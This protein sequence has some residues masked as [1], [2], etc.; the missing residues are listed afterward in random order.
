MTIGNTVALG[1]LVLSTDRLLALLAIAVFIGLVSF[2]TR[3][4]PRPTS[5][6]ATAAVVAGLV[7]GRIGY[8]AMHI[9]SYSDDPLSALAI[10]QGG[11]SVTAGIVGAALVLVATL[12]RSAALHRSLASLG[13]AVMVWAAAAHLL[14]EDAAIPLPKG[15][16]AYTIDG[17]PVAIDSFRGKPFVINLWATWCGPCQREMPML[18]RAA[19]ARPAVPVLFIDQGETPDTVKA[20]LATTRLTSPLLLVDRSQDFSRAVGSGALPTTVFVA[21][22]GMIRESHAGEI[23]RAALDD[24]IDDILETNQ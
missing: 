13:I 24:G 19:A 6:A 18:V 14:V 22:D 16:V 10:W 21:A 3:K 17:R 5:N 12:R 7:M 15:L 23:S 9:P 20:F 1:P 4:S 11:F 2:L 8:V